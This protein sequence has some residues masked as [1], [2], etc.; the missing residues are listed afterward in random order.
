V[1][2]KVLSFLTALSEIE[3]TDDFELLKACVVAD[4]LG[5]KTPRETSAFLLSHGVCESDIAQV[6]HAVLVTAQSP[7]VHGWN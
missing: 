2:A 3:D 7:L 6:F 1:S 5:G 4:I